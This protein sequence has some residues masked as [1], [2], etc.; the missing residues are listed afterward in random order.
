MI[1]N[2][3]VA[4][5]KDNIKLKLLALPIKE[6]RTEELA[7]EVAINIE[8]SIRTEQ[9][10]K[11]LMEIKESTP[12][13]TPTTSNEEDKVEAIQSRSRQQQQGAIQKQ[14]QDNR[15]PLRRITCF[16]CKKT[17]HY[18]RN[19]RQRNRPPWQQSNPWNRQMAQNL[20]NMAN[21]QGQQ[22]FQPRPNNSQQPN[23][24]ALEQY[25]YPMMPYNPDFQ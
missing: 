21:K 16:N 19:C 6:T 24:M 12:L 20:Y 2:K 8:Q 14:N 15:T 17:G 7:K 23:I 10:L 5:L 1:R 3:F 18:A 11:P 13:A 9:L 25:G 4:G 22:F